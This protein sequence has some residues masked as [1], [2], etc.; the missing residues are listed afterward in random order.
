VV[1]LEG[2]TI[3]QFLT[4]LA[5]GVCLPTSDLCLQDQGTSV[6]TLRSY[7]TIFKNEIFKTAGSHFPKDKTPKHVGIKA[8]PGIKLEKS[9]M[10]AILSCRPRYLFAH[11]VSP[12]PWLLLIPFI[13]WTSLLK[14]Q[15]FSEPTELG[16]KPMRTLATP[17]TTK[18]NEDFTT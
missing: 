3:T 8:Y 16:S 6:S 10:I 9:W 11:L 12:S 18:E 13:S 2:L 14:V 4:F 1:T 5:F 15:Q 7:Q 17:N